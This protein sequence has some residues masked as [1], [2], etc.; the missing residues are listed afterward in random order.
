[1]FA[2]SGEITPPCGVPFSTSHWSISPITPALRNASIM[3]STRPSAMCFATSAISRPCGMASKYPRMS[4]S[5]TWTW[6]LLSN[7]STRRSASWLRYPDPFHWL[8]LVDA[9]FDLLIDGEQPRLAVFAEAFHRDAVH[10]AG[11]CVGPHLCPSQ[12]KHVQPADFIDQA[13]PLVSFDPRFEGDQHLLAPDAALRLVALPQVFSPLLIRAGNCRGC[14]FASAFARSVCL[15]AALRSPARYTGSVR[16]GRC[17]DLSAACLRYYGGSDFCRGTIRALLSRQI[18]CVHC[19]LLARPTTTNHTITPH[20]A[21]RC[22]PPQ[23]EVLADLETS[24]FARGLVVLMVPNRVHFRCGRS[25]AFRCSPP[26]LAATRLL[27]VLTRPTVADGRGLSPRMSVQLHSA[28][29]RPILSALPGLLPGRERGVAGVRNVS[30]HTPR[31]EA[32]S[33]AGQAG[34]PALPK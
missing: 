23:V 9:S 22:R 2:S 6:P 17:S 18:S 34:S 24:S 8:G 7:S 19:R 12:R 5:T 10:A 29:A 25:G 15:P 11:P 20:G 32:G 31:G 26:R 28:R 14:F 1:M 27:Q 33:F 13:E 3:P 30:S 21:G 4:M 16:G